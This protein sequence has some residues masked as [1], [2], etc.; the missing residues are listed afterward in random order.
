M[1][2]LF[3]RERLRREACPGGALF[4]TMAG[5]SCVRLAGPGEKVSGAAVMALIAAAHIRIAAPWLSTNFE[6][7]HHRFSLMGERELS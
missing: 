6:P 2:S 4:T 7:V 3:T 1:G 5:D